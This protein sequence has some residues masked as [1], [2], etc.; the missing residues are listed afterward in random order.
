MI[1]V[2]IGPKSAFR[3]IVSICY[4]AMSGGKL[5]DAERAI[6]SYMKWLKAERVRLDQQREDMG[7]PSE[8]Q[9]GGP[10]LSEEVNQ[11]SLPS[12]RRSRTRGS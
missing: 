11:I 1:R 2:H 4:G 5:D 3:N 6:R 12:K 10:P 8:D 7:K 9:R